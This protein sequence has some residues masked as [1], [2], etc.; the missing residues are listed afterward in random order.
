MAWTTV[1]PSPVIAAVDSRDRLRLA[2][3][4]VPVR[5]VAVVAR[6]ERRVEDQVVVAVEL[7]EP[8]ERAPVDER[9]AVV[10][11]LRVALRPGQETVGVLE[12]ALE[13]GGL[14]AIVV[15]NPDDPRVREHRR[16]WPRCRRCG[17]GHARPRPSGLCCH[18]KAT[19]GPS[20]KSL[21][22]P[23]S[24]QMTRARMS[25]DP[26]G[27]PRVASADQQ[28][29]VFVDAYRVQVEVI[30]RGGGRTSTPANG[31]RRDRCGPGCATRRGRDRWRRRSPG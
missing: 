30:P 23:P 9:V 16:G 26:V 29:A 20:A 10:E 15:A 25:V 7:G 6:G 17:S 4:L 28:I 27:G 2:D 22:V 3:P 18:A 12:P 8:R 13:G 21:F 14:A 1:S 24:R 5:P 31:S 19:S 11:R